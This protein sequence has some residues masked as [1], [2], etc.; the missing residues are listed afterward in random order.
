MKR[1]RKKKKKKNTTGDLRTN[2]CFFSFNQVTNV[3]NRQATTSLFRSTGCNQ[4]RNKQTKYYF[5]LFCHYFKS[6]PRTST[7][8]F[9]VS[10][11]FLPNNP[12]LLQLQLEPTNL[13]AEQEMVYSHASIHLPVRRRKRRP[14]DNEILHLP[15]RPTKTVCPHLCSYNHTLTLK[16]RE[17]CGMLKKEKINESRAVC[18]H[19]VVV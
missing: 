9:P 6:S 17:R 18:S 5:Y 12:T 10:P 14:R 19:K 2:E 15:W 3:F 13:S 11:T 16:R 4:R 7:P 1:K 8:T